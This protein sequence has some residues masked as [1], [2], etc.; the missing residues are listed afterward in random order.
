MPPLTTPR[1]ERVEGVYGFLRS[2][3]GYA[4]QF[5]PDSILCAWDNGAPAY[6]LSVFPGYKAHRKKDI[7]D[8]EFRHLQ[9]QLLVITELLPLLGVKQ[10]ASANTE[11]DDLIAVAT[12]VLNYR[13]VIV[14]GDRDLF[15]LIG[16]S[17]RVYNPNHKF[18]YDHLNF[19]PKTG[20]TPEEW[21]TMRVLSG[22][23]SD[24]IPPIRK[25]IGEVTAKKIIRHEK[26][27]EMTDEMRTQFE[28]NK[29]LMQLSHVD[30][31]ERLRKYVS[32]I[33]KERLVL[34]PGQVKY[35]FMSRAFISLLAD[36]P[37]WISAFQ[38]LR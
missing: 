36:F 15:Q 12:R 35:F 34:N 33:A 20:L 31:E 29:K 9:R 7:P 8:K 13:K 30:N 21:Y 19:K 10:A 27:I 37:T 5:N 1:K 14:S 26:T 32:I 23:T 28:T 24:G 2:L 18:L 4:E 17:V 11:A 6:R 16:P 38:S 3:H 25:G 22:D